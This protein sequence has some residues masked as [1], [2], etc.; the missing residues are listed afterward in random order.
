MEC[1]NGI[2]ALL[3]WLGKIAFLLLHG[4]YE[5]KIGR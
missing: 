1:M 5:C 4:P 3:K 2:L